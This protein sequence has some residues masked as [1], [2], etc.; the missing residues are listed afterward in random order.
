[1]LERVVWVQTQQ[2]L[3]IHDFITTDQATY[4]KKQH[5]TETAMHKV[6]LELLDN[7][8]EEMLRVR[9]VSKLFRNETTYGQS[10]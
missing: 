6:I 8:N 4:L 5:C 7:V 10:K 1:M 2:Y 9:V 3:L